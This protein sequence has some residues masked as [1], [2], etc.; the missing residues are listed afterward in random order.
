VGTISVGE[1]TLAGAAWRYRLLVLV[2]VIGFVGVGTIYA[3]VH[4]AV[5]SATA[6]MVLQDPHSD[7]VFANSTSQPPERYTSDQIAV[8]KS[9]ELAAAAAAVGAAK[10]PPL[11]LTAADFT[12]HTV[13]AGTPTS[14]NLVQVT[15]TS[16]DEPTALGGLDAIRTA[17]QQTVHNAV[18]AQL[19]SLLAQIDS[20]LAAINTEL[21]GLAAKLTGPAQPNQQA[22]VQQQSALITQGQTLSA[23]RDQV[24]VD[25]ASGSNGV[26]LYLAPTA[27]TH[28]S[29]LVAA[30]PLLSVAAVAGL[31]LGLLAAY[32]LASRRR[33]FRGRDEPASVLG[34]ALVAEIPRFGRSHPLPAADGEPAPAATAFRSAALLIQ[35]RQEADAGRSG[36]RRRLRAGAGRLLVVSGARGEGRSTVAANLGIALADRG[37]STLLIDADPVTGGLSEL[38]HE[39]YELTPAI[40]SRVRLTGAGMSLENIMRPGNSLVRLVLLG[41][42]RAQ[43]SLDDSDRDKRLDELESTFKVVVIDGPPL[44]DAGP[45]W[46]LVRRA[47]SAIVLVTDETSVAQLEEVSRL[48]T[49]TEIPA[50]GYVYNHRPRPRR[51]ER[52]HE[53][54]PSPLDTIHPGPG[55]TASA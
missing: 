19:A 39:R 44:S 27:A 2:T 54:T 51:A 49:A 33:V 32:V 30:L 21:A 1:P 46:P 38:L 15:F 25:A 11:H 7:P 40:D 20:E 10:K 50:F 29:K 26:S 42:G 13:V 48:L 14:G 18:S 5:Y 53:T 52:A 6:T 3:E 23:K 9:P 12:A 17:Y 16:S 41:A 34:A 24:M 35:V 36:P 31:A 47:E 43:L 55:L 4:G 45:Y 22:L 8:L 28:S 37:M